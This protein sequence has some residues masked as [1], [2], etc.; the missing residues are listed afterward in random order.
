M[1]RLSPTLLKDSDRNGGR[2]RTESSR[3]FEPKTWNV[4]GSITPPIGIVP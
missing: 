4:A 1:L 2:I 3:R